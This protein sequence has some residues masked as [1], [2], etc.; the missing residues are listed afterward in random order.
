MDRLITPEK[1]AAFAG[2][3]LLAASNSAAGPTFRAGL[4]LFL[5]AMAAIIVLK[6]TDTALAAADARD[7]RDRRDE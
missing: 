5:T 1:Q 2:L 7:P 4:V 6:V 3:A